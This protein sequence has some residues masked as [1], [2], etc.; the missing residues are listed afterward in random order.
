MSY[1]PD[2]CER[3][4]CY[5]SRE[6]GTNAAWVYHRKRGEEPCW[7]ARE[8]MDRYNTGRRDGRDGRNCPCCGAHEIRWHRTPHG[9]SDP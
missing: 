4:E 7:L 1:D 8:A 3:P 2:N 5:E 6:K 9:V